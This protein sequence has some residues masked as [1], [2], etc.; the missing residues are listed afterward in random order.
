MVIEAVQ[1]DGLLKALREEISTAVLPDTTEP[2]Q[3]EFD[4]AKL[5]SLPLLSSV[6][7]ETLRLRISTT[8]TRL[9]LNDLT[10]DGYVLKAGNCLMVPSWLAHTEA[11]W[12]SEGHPATSFWP[13]R[14]L[15]RTGSANQKSKATSSTPAP[16][17]GTYF[18]FGGGSSMCPGRFFA[19][20]EILTAVGII[21][22][23][24]DIELI[25]YIEHDGKNSERGPE[26]DVRKAGSGALL[27]DRDIMVRVRKH[28]PPYHS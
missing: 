23:R 16:S 26:P 24:F 13:E 8:P 7:T 5:L 18:P 27:P 22:L 6:L 28:P 19:K 14:F 12:S 20:Q 1:N 4:I 3:I 10:V 2:R 21:I 11:Q 17:P 25:R 15:E 9:L